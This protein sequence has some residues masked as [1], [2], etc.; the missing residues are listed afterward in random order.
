MVDKNGNDKRLIERTETQLR[1]AFERGRPEP[2]PEREGAI[3]AMPQ[4]EERTSGISK[5]R[6]GW[7]TLTVSRR[8]V[9][10]VGA[11]ALALVLAFVF[12]DIFTTAPFSP[13]QSNPSM[14]AIIL[15]RIAGNIER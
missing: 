10:A 5:L 4:Q 12:S 14:I 2:D 15:V 6:E 9:F 3:L 11:A 8:R 7:F 1:A 13:N